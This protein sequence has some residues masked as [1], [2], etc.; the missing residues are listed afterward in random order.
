MMRTLQEGQRYDRYEKRDVGVLFVNRAWELGYDEWQRYYREATGKYTLAPNVTAL[1]KEEAGIL[2]MDLL[3]DIEHISEP[4]I[5]MSG[6]F[7]TDDYNHIVFM[8]SCISTQVE[9]RYS[10]H[11]P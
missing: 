3:G 7:D 8:L 11:R 4:Y 10:E 2:L 6:R 1:T 9:S 5:S